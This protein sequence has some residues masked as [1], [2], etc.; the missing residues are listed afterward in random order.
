MPFPSVSRID[1]LPGCVPSFRRQHLGES[2]QLKQCS[3]IEN[4][5][6]RN[7]RTLQLAV[8]MRC[9]SK[10]FTRSIGATSF[11]FLVMPQA[12][13]VIQFCLLFS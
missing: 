5:D 10:N 13:L 9:E 8:Q 4:A 2:F 1:D 12:T 11:L 7:N 3:P 6:R